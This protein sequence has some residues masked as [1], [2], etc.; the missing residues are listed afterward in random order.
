MVAAIFYGH[1][2]FGKYSAISLLTNIP[3]TIFAVAYYELVLR[4]SF[5]MIAQGHGRR[6][7]WFYYLF[8]VV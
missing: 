2:A 1:D 6:K 7:F 3:A 5:A 8:F 4:D